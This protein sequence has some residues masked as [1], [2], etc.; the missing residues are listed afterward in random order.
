MFITC[1]YRI[2]V[3][4][5]Q[6]L[7]IPM[8]EQENKFFEDNLSEFLETKKGKYVLVFGTEL[9]GTFESQIDA[10][11]EGYEKFKEKPFFV[12]QVLPIQEPLNF[13]NNSLLI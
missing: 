10:L 5:R 4:V 11:S 7:S 1:R 13:T 6:Q 12:R 3:L 8:L 2:F 9:I